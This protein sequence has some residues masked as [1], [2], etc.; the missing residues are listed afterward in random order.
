MAPLP[1]VRTAMPVPLL[2]ETHTHTPLCKHAQGQFLDYAQVAQ[3]RGL[4]GLLVTCHNPLPDGMAAGSRMDPEQFRQYLDAVHA[5]HDT[6]ADLTDV[7]LGIE[8]DYLPGLEPF[9]TEQL[10]TAPFEYVLGSIHPPLPE[11]SQRCLDNDGLAFQKGYFRHLADMAETGLFDT[12]AH[13]DVIKNLFPDTWRLEPIMDHICRCLDRIARTGIAMELNTSGINKPVP[14]MNPSQPILN[15]MFAR[16]IP[17][18]IGGDAH[19]PQRVGDGYEDAMQMLLDVGYT[20]T[21][22]FLKRQRHDVAI[23]DALES[24]LP[25]TTTAD[26]PQE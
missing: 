21:S 14:E 7:R 24:L 2:Y 17:V 19:V 10:A 13:P 16:N 15:E 25:A 5:A 6:C 1:T 22:F 23:A 4:K 8:C 18:V 9:L 12:L 26:T 11:Y 20:K 3:Q